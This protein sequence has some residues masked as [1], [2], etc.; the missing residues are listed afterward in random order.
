M[1]GW[2]SLESLQNYIYIR[3]YWIKPWKLSDTSGGIIVVRICFLGFGNLCVNL[4][5]LTHA[6]CFCWN[7]CVNLQSV[8]RASCFCWNFCVNL[9]SVIR[10]SCFCWNFC[11]NLQSVIRASCFCWNIC[12][13]LQSVIRASFF[14]DINPRK[15]NT[16]IKKL[17]AQ[18]F[19]LVVLSY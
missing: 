10:A 14:V 19:E 9:Q 7:L 17:S 2:R 6:S 13:N 5:S 11:V 4:Q 1:K 15:I 16:L 18:F 3:M 8:I 12:V